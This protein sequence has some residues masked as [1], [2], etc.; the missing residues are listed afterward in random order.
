MG[1]EIE[2]KF[3]VKDDS[4]RSHAESSSLIRQGYMQNDAHAT[5]RVRLID[6]NAYLTLKAPRSASGVSRL[7]Y[8][9][10]I[11]AQ[12]AAGLLAAICT[13]PL[14]EK[15]RYY[16]PAGNCLTWEIDEFFGDNAG[17]IVAE[18]EL[19]AEDA[20]VPRPS[21]LGDEVTGDVRYYN[22][23]IAKHPYSTWNK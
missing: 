23:H 2:R 17:L 15:R 7:E 16:I 12:D 22:S 6:D 11:P 9:S 20:E 18:L 14:V 8:E 1:V 5:V 13:P 10:P 3:L 19:P 21:W 4:W